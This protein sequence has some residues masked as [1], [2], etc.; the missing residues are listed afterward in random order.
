MSYKGYNFLKM[1]QKNRRN[2]GKIKSSVEEALR[3]L[4]A[5]MS[6]MVGGFGLCGIPVSLIDFISKEK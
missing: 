1:I 5:G 4:R 6:V 3:P 2:F